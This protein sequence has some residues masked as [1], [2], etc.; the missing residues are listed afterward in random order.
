MT[1]SMWSEF[2]RVVGSPDSTPLDVLQVVGVYQRYLEAIEKEAV[3]AARRM[4]ATWEDIGASLGVT[5]QSAWQRLRH[6]EDEI[7]QATDADARARF[8]DEVLRRMKHPPRDA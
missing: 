3:R 1:E 6:L 8:V 2:E 7:K 5:R 4:G